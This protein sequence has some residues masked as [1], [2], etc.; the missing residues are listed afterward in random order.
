MT[1]I[2]LITRF[3]S[4]YRDRANHVVAGVFL[5][6]ELEEQ[7]QH[8]NRGWYSTCGFQHI[9][10]WR[11]KLR[12]FFATD[13][14]WQG[15]CVRHLRITAQQRFENIDYISCWTVVLLKLMLYVILILCDLWITFPAR[16]LKDANKVLSRA[17]ATFSG[18]R[19][20]VQVLIAASQLYVEKGR[21]I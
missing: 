21:N 10:W 5:F 8:G 20:E 4:D 1:F 3:C 13:G 16:R 19:Q 2:L 17:K 15:E 9:F 18:T 6:V 12:R 14:R 11:W 7:Q